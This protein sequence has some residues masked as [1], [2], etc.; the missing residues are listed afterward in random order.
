VEG[1]PIRWIDP[2]GLTKYSLGARVSI[3]A[4]GVGGIYG[5]SF[6]R[7][8]SGK[9]CTTIVSC[10]RVG[11][12]ASFGAKGTA[13]VG[14]GDFCEGDSESVGGF[15]TVGYGGIGSVA[16]QTDITTGDTSVTVTAGGGAGASGGGQVCL[17]KVICF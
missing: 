4:G 7:D 15:G 10:G 13:T 12:G 8:T 2:R 5:A 6:G 11:F 9:Y 16:T 14:Q 17:T 1:N 3:F